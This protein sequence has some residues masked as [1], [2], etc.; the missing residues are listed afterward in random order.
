MALVFLTPTKQLRVGDT[1]VTGDTGPQGALWH[2]TE[3]SSVHRLGSLTSGKLWNILESP[4]IGAL[5]FLLQ[6]RRG[7]TETERLRVGE[8]SGLEPRSTVLIRAMAPAT[9]VLCT[10]DAGFLLRK[11][12][13]PRIC[14]SD[15]EPTR[16]GKW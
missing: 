5:L 13:C 14:L 8:E 2:R 4:L 12:L 9:A 15:R 11:S 1:M 3:P 6:I 16:V 7:E 10:C